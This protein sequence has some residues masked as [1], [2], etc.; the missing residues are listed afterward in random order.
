M[1]PEAL[2]FDEPF[3]ALDPHL[4]RSTEEQLRATLRSFSG[5]VLFVTHDMEEA[6]RF[7]SD[8][9]VIDRG[10]LLASG[11]RQQLFERPGSVTAARLT[12]CKN[13]AQCGHG[14]AHSRADA[15]ANALFIPEWQ[16]AL[17]LPSTKEDA[18][19]IG[20]RSHH[21]RFQREA[22][23]A[24]VFLCWLVETSE[25][26]HEMTLYL[27]LHEPPERE[28]PV[29]GA[30]VQADIP[31]AQWRALAVQPQPWKI[32]FVPEQILVLTDERD[33]S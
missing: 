22:E 8:L 15:P 20:Y 23:G 6:F 33:A 1:Q 21:F 9:A 28:D 4:R 3:A 25:S 16:C 27:R 29:R 2:L 14:S 10:R 24:N 11:P 12:G 7:C 32:Q 30:H 18:V 17:V 13:I 5:P 31:K 26:A 19:A